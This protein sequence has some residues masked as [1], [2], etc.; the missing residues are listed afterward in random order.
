MT[1]QFRGDPLDPSP[2]LTNAGV[3]SVFNV[4]DESVPP[5][6]SRLLQSGK[7]SVL[8]TGGWQV[9]PTPDA[10]LCVFVCVFFYFPPPLIVSTFQV[11]K[12]ES[13]SQT[14]TVI[15]A[16][17]HLF[18][19]G[20]GVALQTRKTGRTLNNSSTSLKINF[21][22]MEEKRKKSGIDGRGREKAGSKI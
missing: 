12:T 4:I 5:E 21:T 1:L 16:N 8:L 7:R 22:V 15:S 14:S 11:W 10:P 20:A 6:K 2:Y 19:L 13:T 17:T 18:T 9:E 3:L